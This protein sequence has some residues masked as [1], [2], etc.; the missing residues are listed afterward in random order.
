MKAFPKAFLTGLFST[1]V[2]L[3]A[4]SASAVE[5]PSNTVGNA[6]GEKNLNDVQTMLSSGRGNVDEILKA[7]LKQ[8]QKDMSVD[9]DFSHKM[10]SLAGQYAPKISPPSAFPLFA[11]ICVASNLKFEHAFCPCLTVR[12]SLKAFQRLLSLLQLAV[13]T[14]VNKRFFS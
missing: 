12:I 3:G 8:T 11:P 10:M 7:L 4:A 1:A 6:L 14:N 2:F 13:P 5:A 9:A